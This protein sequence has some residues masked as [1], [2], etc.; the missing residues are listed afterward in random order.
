MTS[1]YKFTKNAGNKNSN[2]SRCG[3]LFILVIT[4]KS[5]SPAQIDKTELTTK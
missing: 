4:S 1:L 5:S 3:E 2:I